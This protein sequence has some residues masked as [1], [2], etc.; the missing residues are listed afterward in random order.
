[1]RTSILQNLVEFQEQAAKITDVPHGVKQS[2]FWV[3]NNS[4][5]WPH[6][7][8][9]H[10]NEELL[11]HVLHEIESEKLP[12]FWIMENQY[13]AEQIQLLEKNEFR[14]INRWE[15]MYMKP[16]GFFQ[17]TNYAQNFTIHRVLY[18]HQAKQWWSIVKPIMMPNRRLPEGLL[19]AWVLRSEYEL[20]VGMYNGKIV[21]AG[22]SFLHKQIAG[23]YFIVTLPDFRGKGYA[24]ILVNELMKINF[25]KGATEIILHA[26]KLG[27]P[28]YEKIGF[29][30]EGAISTYWKVGLF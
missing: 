28:M 1:M 25:E 10:A 6:S 21:S 2:L 24:S 3:M 27:L 19:D 30:G 5:F 23:L 18:Q 26:S 15:G 22:M 17:V 14:E 9:G 4:G 12:S 29:I 11:N 7:I 16:N 8:I 20:L 13:S